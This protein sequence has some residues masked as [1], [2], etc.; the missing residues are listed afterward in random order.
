ARGILTSQG[1]KS[2]HAAIVAR[3]MGRPC[4]CG[5]S[6]VLID[7][8]NG[9][10][11]SGAVGGHAGDRIAIDGASGVVTADDVELVEPRLDEAFT[12]ILSCARGLRPPRARAHA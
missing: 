1:G 7:P 6:E 9:I 12:Q 2:S 3:G 11:R 10:V 5:A 8:G 4:I